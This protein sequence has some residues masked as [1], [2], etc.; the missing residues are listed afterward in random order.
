[1]IDFS[2]DLDKSIINISTNLW[3]ITVKTVGTK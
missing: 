2:V 3:L 1:M